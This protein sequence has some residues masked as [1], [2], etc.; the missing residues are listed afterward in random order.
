MNKYLWVSLFLI[1][2]AVV[3]INSFL[4]KTTILE[5]H[6]AS[7]VLRS[8]ME[9]N[10]DGKLH[11]RCTEYHENGTVKSDSR[12]SH[13]QWVEIIE[14]DESGKQTRHAYHDWLFRTIE[15]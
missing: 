14:Y 11:G 13:D 2:L 10:S 7:G 12:Y 8:R 3:A 15:E 6:F 5:S 9:L 4:G 1:L